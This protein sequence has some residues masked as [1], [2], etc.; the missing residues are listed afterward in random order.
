MTLKESLKQELDK[1]NEE[2]LKQVANFIA[3]VE[4]A[5][6]RVNIPF[7]QTATPAQRA[8]R[9]CESVA[10]RGT[11]SPNLPDAALRRDSIYDA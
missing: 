8:A 7:W 6:T 2:Q 3:F 1:L 11:A 4:F 10:P 5:T 9:W